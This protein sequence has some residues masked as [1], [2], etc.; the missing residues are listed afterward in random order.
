MMA[1]TVTEEAWKPHH[2][3]ITT[4]ADKLAATTP[5]TMIGMALK[6]L[7]PI[8]LLAWQVSAN[9]GPARW[10]PM[11]AWQL[12]SRRLFSAVRLP[13]SCRIHHRRAA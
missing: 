10:P 8:G 9:D 7:G 11:S 5:T 6:C 13:Q 2:D 12:S 1:G 4:L 3:A